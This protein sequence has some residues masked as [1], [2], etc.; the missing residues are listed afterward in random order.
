MAKTPSETELDRGTLVLATDRGRVRVGCSSAQPRG[1]L[2]WEEIEIGQCLRIIGLPASQARA[3]VLYRE[4]GEED[5]IDA[6]WLAPVRWARRRTGGLLG[7][8]ALFAV[9]GITHRDEIRAA[10][11]EGMVCPL[12]TRPAVQQERSTRVA[13]CYRPGSSV[14]HGPLVRRIRRGLRWIK[15]AEETY[16]D[17]RLRRRSRFDQNGQLAEEGGYERG[18]RHG[19]WRWRCRSE[20]SVLQRGTYDHGRRRG[21]WSRDSV[22]R[23]EWTY[24][25]Q[26]DII[27]WTRRSSKGSARGDVHDGRV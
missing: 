8:M 18:E 21:T 9:L 14:R 6:L 15:E 23:E 27:S 10:V 4:P 25:D 12:G 19:S 17:G 3:E 24:D 20:A 5:V 2:R 22:S 11:T 26:G 7:G 13:A 16:V 1:P